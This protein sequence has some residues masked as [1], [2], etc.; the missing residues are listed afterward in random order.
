[1]LNIQDKS[2]FQ[3]A[4]YCLL[5][6]LCLETPQCLAKSREFERP[7]SCLADGKLESRCVIGSGCD[8][9]VEPFGTVA[10]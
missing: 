9:P 8:Q 1:M 2:S 3:T 5:P 6:S 4:Y 10:L 7:L